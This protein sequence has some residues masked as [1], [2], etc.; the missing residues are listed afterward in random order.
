MISKLECVLY[1]QIALIKLIE[2]KDTIEPYD[3]YKEMCNLLYIPR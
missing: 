2:E 1:A 3:L